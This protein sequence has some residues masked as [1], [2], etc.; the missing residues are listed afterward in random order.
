MP[1]PSPQLDDLRYDSVV[2]S[3]MRRIPVYTPEW[4]DWNDSD[5]G[6][7]LIQLFAYL[8]EQ[9]GYRLNQVPEKTYVELL[10]LLGVQLRSPTAATSRLGVFLAAPTTF[11]AYTL[12][13]RSRFTGNTSTAVFYES[14]LDVDIAPAQPFTLL[15]TKNPYL[16]DLL[17]QDAR[18]ER[19]PAPT[20]YEL[21]KQVPTSDCR[22][23][24]VVWDGA[25]PAG[26][27]MPLQPVT[28]LP[29]SSSGVAHP[30]LWLGVT[31]NVAPSAGFAGVA[32]T[33]T[34][35]FD[36]DE[37]PDPRADVECLPIN[38]AG[39]NQPP[40]IDWLAYF[41]ASRNTMVQVPGRIDD[42]TNKLTRSGDISFTVPVQVGPIPTAMFANLRDAV[43][44]TPVDA[45]GGLGD[46]M[47]AALK[48]TGTIDSSALQTLITNAVMA[49]Q[50]QTQQTVTAVAHPLDP[51][52]RDPTKVFCWLR[53]G[54][55]DTSLVSPK[56]RF[57]GFNVVPV[58]NAVTVTS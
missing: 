17:L 48:P 20:A 15:A 35:Q 39:E 23:L 12:D 11:A 10:K 45:C 33:L 50:A 29:Q 49:S 34:I 30:Y 14:D 21:P 8:A 31:A 26:P 3:L 56:L 55:L 47:L 2:Q 25:K 53:I 19:D 24:T 18:G 13:A 51:A 44:P 4:T 36:D 42:S 58:T 6:I 40:P 9:V 52:L 46:N 5:P 1:L 7:T 32:A 43:T 54:P 28:L 22:W 38:A 41:D 57:I 27:D 16:W 37:V